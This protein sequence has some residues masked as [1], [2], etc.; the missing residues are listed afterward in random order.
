M[1]YYTKFNIYDILDFN[2][3]AKIACKC[4]NSADKYGFH[5]EIKNVKDCVLGAFADNKKQGLQTIRYIYEYQFRSNRQEK[6]SK[7]DKTLFDAFLCVQNTAS[8][9]FKVPRTYVVIGKI[10]AENF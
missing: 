10:N 8:H 9:S 7:L 4:N 1:P 6:D 5:L 2:L 3:S